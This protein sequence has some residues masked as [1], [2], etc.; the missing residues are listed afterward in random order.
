[1]SRHL[2]PLGA[3]MRC[4]DPRRARRAV[5]GLGLSFLTLGAAG[6]TEKQAESKQAQKRPPVPVAVARVE[7]KAMPL[8]IQAIGTVEAY[9]VVSVRAQVGGE[10]TRVHVK[11][12]QDVRKGDLLFTIDPRTAQAL[13]DQAQANLAK[14]RVQVQQARATLERDAARVAQARAT[15]AR[16]QAQAANAEVQARRYTDLL[17]KDLVSREQHDQ[18]QTALQA[19]AATVQ[20][21]EADVRS[22]EETVRADQ[23]A[24][25][26][27]EEVVRADEAAVANAKVLLGYTTIRSPLDGRAG[28]LGLHEGNVVRAT[29][30]NDSTLLVINQIQPIYV[31]F[32]VPQQQLPAVKRYMAE[33]TLQVQ[34]L[35]S[36]DPKPVRGT[37]TFVDNSVDTTTG[38]IRLKATFANEE[39]R[40]WPGQFVNVTLTLT[41]E[42]DAI[43]VPAQA[44]Q[45][46][47]QGMQYVFVV[48]PDSTVDNRRVTV[49]R[50]QGAETIIAKGLTPGEQV[51]TDGQPR[52]TPGTK[53]EVR[54]GEGRGGRPGGEGGAGR[55]PRP[56]GGGD[57][58]G[59]GGAERSGG[60]AERPAG[61]AEKPGGGEKP[62]GAPGQAGADKAGRQ[63]RPAGTQ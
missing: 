32:T 30:T 55:G 63:G 60:G 34:V 16:D 22:A 8:Q 17:R 31:S 44:V 10:L 62:A 37:V 42:P 43:V 28:S 57:K 52:L 19:L 9:S 46:G 1:M 26:S 39:K 12:G 33:G 23:A 35:P 45:S 51:V 61:G 41:T 36:G 4:R 38:T 48:K 53:V 11:E 54:T 7:Q 21:D 59:G 24:I 49:E 29:G 3:A 6:C 50:T 18:Y 5:L 56:Q 13:V 27:A 25:G 15:L 20:A 14:S 47:Q 40:L 58:P 2:L